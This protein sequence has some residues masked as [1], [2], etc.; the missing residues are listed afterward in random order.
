VIVLS[1]SEGFA[2]PVV[3]SQ[4]CGTP[5]VVPMNGAQAEVAGDAGVRVD[6]D[7]A[8]SVAAGIERALRDREALR[9]A[10]SANAARFTWSRCATL[11]ERVWE[12]L[13]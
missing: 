2:F 6:A 13:A 10:G 12:E 1:H 4:A 3:E 5:V 9:V 11:V 8:E 7:D